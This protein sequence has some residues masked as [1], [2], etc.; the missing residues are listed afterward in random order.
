VPIE[1]IETHSLLPDI[2]RSGG[3]VVDCGANIGAFSR[4]MID[5]F[6]CRVLAYEA[7]PETFQR[8][9]RL[10]GLDAHNI[11]VTGTEGLVKIGLKDDTARSSILSSRKAAQRNAV[12]PGCRLPILLAEARVEGEI[13]VLKLD[14]EGA[15]IDVIDSLPDDFIRRIAEGSDWR[16]T[17]SSRRSSDQLEQSAGPRV[18]SVATETRFRALAAGDDFLRTRLVQR[19][20]TDAENH[21]GSLDVDAFCAA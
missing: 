14:I 11:A 9:P 13:E 5:R 8:L 1:H 20:S 3:L 2:I 18:G 21:S 6:R 12:V 19:A 17:P 15:E 4:A 16:D 10:P 7:S